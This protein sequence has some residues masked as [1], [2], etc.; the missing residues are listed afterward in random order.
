[1][2]N[3]IKMGFLC[4]TFRPAFFRY[5]PHSD[6]SHTSVLGVQGNNGEKV[7]RHEM[8]I[9]SLFSRGVKR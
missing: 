3:N 4:D 7:G 8:K 5:I 6:E 9:G 2:G 1:M